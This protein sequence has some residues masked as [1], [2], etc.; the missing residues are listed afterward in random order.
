MSLLSRCLPNPLPS[1]IRRA[2][3]EPGLT[4]FPHHPI[5]LNPDPPPRPSVWLAVLDN[6]KHLAEKTAYLLGVTPGS[7]T[8]RYSPEPM[9]FLCRPISDQLVNHLVT[10][11]TAPRV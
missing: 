4:R 3:L 7:Q 10:Q 6:L 5:F 2:G 9:V 11:Q 8:E 1:N